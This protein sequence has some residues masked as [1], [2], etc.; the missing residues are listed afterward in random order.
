MS[1][2][3][4]DVQAYIIAEGLATVDGVDIFRDFIPEAPDNM[5]SVAEYAGVP[6]SPGIDTQLRM[7]QISVRNTSYGTARS[8]SHQLY[9][10]FHQPDD[11]I[12]QLTADRWVISQPRQTP[13]QSGRD[14]RNRS[15]FVFNISLT[16]FKDV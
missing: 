14:K 10:M 13:F 16:T 11:L 5:I 2:L 6:G 15:T 8:T 1:D 9:A 4:E 3:L 12:M 7:V